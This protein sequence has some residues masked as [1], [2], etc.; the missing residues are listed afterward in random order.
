MIYGDLTGQRFNKLTVICKSDKV[1]GVESYYW[2]Q[3]ECGELACVGKYQLTGRKVKSCGCLRGKAIKHGYCGTPTYRSWYQMLYRCR[4]KNGHAY[5]QYGGRGIK[6]CKSWYIFENFLTDM[7]VRPEG[8]S[9]DRIDNNAGYFPEN[10]RWATPSEQQ[11]NRNVKGYSQKKNG[12]WEA[13]ITRNGK[14]YYLGSFDSEKE[15]KTIYEKAKDK[16]NKF[17][18]VL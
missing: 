7:G 12:K 5:N 14:Y 3:C 10:C 18:K 11:F 17:G 2:C 4:N 13:S 6:V 1:V 9:L 15:A 16:F 8:K